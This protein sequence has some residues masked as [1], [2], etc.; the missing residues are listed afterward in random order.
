MKISGWAKDTN[1][2]S[3]SK[4]QKKF[5]LNLRS[6]KAFAARWLKVPASRV[7]FDPGGRSGRYIKTID[8]SEDLRRLISLGVIRVKR[9]K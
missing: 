2:P 1:N 6:K 3:Y 8:T 4:P 9:K 7:W 5:R